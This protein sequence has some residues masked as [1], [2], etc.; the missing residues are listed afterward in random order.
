MTTH[1]EFIAEQCRTMPIRVLSRRF[2]G[3]WFHKDFYPNGAEDML[4]AIG[5]AM[6]ERSTKEKRAVYM[7][8]RK[9]YFKLKDEYPERAMILRDMMHYFVSE[10][11]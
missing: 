8:I 5:I 2:I 7:G 4:E 11:L 6:H 1:V 10:F 3:T 9:E